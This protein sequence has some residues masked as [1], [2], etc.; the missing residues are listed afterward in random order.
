MSWIIKASELYEHA[1]Y[2]HV[3]I[4]DSELAAGNDFQILHLWSIRAPP[5]EADSPAPGV[6]GI[7]GAD[8]NAIVSSPL[9]EF[10]A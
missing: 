2:A 7:I 9:N 8:W 10:P 1:T 6:A 4:P 3:C 5:L